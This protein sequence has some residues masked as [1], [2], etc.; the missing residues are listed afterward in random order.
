MKQKHR[1]CVAISA[2]ALLSFKSLAADESFSGLGTN[3]GNLYRTSTAQTRS[4]SAENPGGEPGK[5]G[6]ASDGTGKHA[7]RELGQG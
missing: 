7:A 1:Y 3:L 6:S 5:G 4:I 2:L